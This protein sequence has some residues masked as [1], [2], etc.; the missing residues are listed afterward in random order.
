MH[1]CDGANPDLS[2][3]LSRLNPKIR[4]NR[5]PIKLGSTSKS[6]ASK[7]ASSQLR[8]RLA[9]LLKDYSHVATYHISAPCCMEINLWTDGYLC[10]P[11][12]AAEP[13]KPFPRCI[14]EVFGP[15][16]WPGRPSGSE[17]SSLGSSGIGN[18]VYLRWDPRWDRESTAT[19]TFEYTP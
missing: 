6:I 13:G 16:S 10:A 3:V 12:M 2:S 1:A 18:R 19:E 5:A 4:G 8:H 14:C 9:H 17:S 15:F 7:G 11:W